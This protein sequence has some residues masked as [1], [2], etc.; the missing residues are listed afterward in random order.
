MAAFA[1]KKV[2]I[3]KSSNLNFNLFL[4]NLEHLSVAAVETYRGT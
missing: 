3:L 1:L 2:H 4:E